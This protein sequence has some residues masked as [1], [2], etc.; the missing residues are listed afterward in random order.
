MLK[1]YFWKLFQS[2]CQDHTIVLTFN[3]EE[4]VVGAI[5]VHHRHIPYHLETTE[6]SYSLILIN[7]NGIASYYQPQVVHWLILSCQDS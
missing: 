6:I 7:C 4:M 5:Q 1:L 2:D 3:I